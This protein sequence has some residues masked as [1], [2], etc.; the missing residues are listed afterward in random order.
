MTIREVPGLR[1]KAEALEEIAILLGAAEHWDDPAEYLE[2]FANIIGKVMPHP[3]DPS[4]NDYY[5]QLE[6]GT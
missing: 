4:N 2:T 3:G 6:A 5:Q 1:P